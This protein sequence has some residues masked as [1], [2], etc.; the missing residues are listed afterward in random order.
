MPL[1]T[2]KHP[3]GYSVVGTRLIVG[4]LAER[5]KWGEPLPWG[6]WVEGIDACLLEARSKSEALRYLEVIFAEGR[7]MQQ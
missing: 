5:P 6:V 7:K 4:K 3:E 1:K 2:T